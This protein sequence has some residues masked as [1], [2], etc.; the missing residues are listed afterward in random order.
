MSKRLILLVSIISLVFLSCT[1][2]PKPVAKI[3]GNWIS[4]EQWDKFLESRNIKDKNDNEKLSKALDDLI[5]REVAY[6]KA[7]R[8]GLLAGSQWDDQQSR[9][10]RSV[11]I[12]NYIFKTYL[13]NSKEPSKEELADAFKLNNSQRHLWGI[14]V[15]GKE[16]AI[17]VCKELREGKD[18]KE[19]FEKHK[20]DLENGP[21]SY[22]MGNASFNSMPQ[23]IQKYFFSGKDG[24]VLDPVPFRDENSFIVVVLKELITPPLPEKFDDNLIMRASQLR[25]QKAVL[26]ANDEL[27]EKYP[28]SLDV[29]LVEELIKNDNPTAE[30]LNKNVG[31]VGSQKIKYVDFLDAYYNE[32]QK[33][34]QM[35][36]RTPEVFKMLFDKIAA[37]QRI[38]ISAKEKGFLKDSDV[39]LEVWNR[40]H[41]SG[42]ARFFQ[43]FLNEAVV[44]EED[45]KNY[46]EKNKDNF[47]GE[48]KFK[49]KYL[50]AESP[51]AINQAVGLFKKGAKWEDL[52]KIEGIL[53]ETG[54]GVLDWKS[55]SELSYLMSKS[56]IE[57]LKKM[58]KGK[59]LAD[60]MQ[61]RFVAFYLEDR[62]DPPITPFDECRE[63]VKNRYIRENGV[64]LFD[65][66]IEKDARKEIKVVTF[67]QN[68]K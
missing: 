23:E 28:E 26:K 52:L 68:I 57:K 7:K 33:R 35:L 17:E 44:N 65:E 59:W 2:P 32:S 62:E 5:K 20:N 30:E 13:N 34:Q 4:Y 56:N 66:Y 54:Q 16:S 6:E 46:Y 25:Y 39:K 19:L 40:V 14:G 1:K 38:F 21:Q 45:L 37:E 53:Q 58:E 15:K 8:K 55:E 36:P 9:I 63:E 49:L 10:E 47:K 27:K 18:I 12:S 64:K 3:G 31:V 61:K 48:V 22:D 51:D 50:L 29:K 11:V 67:S 24:D 43:D 60:K 41:E 42:A